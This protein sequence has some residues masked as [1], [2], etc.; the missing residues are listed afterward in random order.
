MK[1]SHISNRGDRQGFTLVE[2]LVVLVII[3]ILVS[4][5]GA[6]V[7]KGWFLGKSARNRVDISQIEVSLGTF[8]NR[9]GNY[10]P[11][12][13]LLLCEKFQD[14]QTFVSQYPAYQKLAVDSLAFLT[15]IFPK[16]VNQPWGQL[17]N[18][19]PLY[20]DPTYPFTYNNP[21]IPLAN[22]FVDWN[23]DKTHSLPVILEGDQCLVFFLGGIPAPSTASV[24]SILPN[25][26]P[27][28][29]GFAADDHN[30]ANANSTDRIGP[31]YDFNSSR[32]V[33]LPPQA[34]NPFRSTFFYSYLDTYG[35]SDG[36]GTL[37][38]GMPYAYFSTYK[39]PNAYN[40][41]LASECPTVGYMNN[42]AI[43][44]LSGPGLWPYAEVSLVGSTLLQTPRYLKPNSFQIISAGADQIFGPGSLPVPN[45]QTGAIAFQQVWTSNSASTVYPQGTPGYDDQ[46]NFSS[47]LLGA[48]GN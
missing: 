32:L 2:L 37:V 28:C 24:G 33:V 36:F 34:I 17:P 39:G 15:R 48:S 21:G 9:F 1:Q 40:T 5:I 10:A 12:S 4:L 41:Y 30:P 7:I 44:N 16:M 46:S 22:Q 38:S 31:L 8:Q 45:P 18:G 43:N 13:M 29:L 27:A 19:Q 47:G 20:G 14:Y 23:G 35:T 11:P 6:A 42:V 25:T 3:G 26:P